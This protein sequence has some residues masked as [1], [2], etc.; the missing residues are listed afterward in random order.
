MALKNTQA[1]LQYYF[2]S[3]E[4]LDLETCRTIT[5]P[6]QVT[7]G[8]II[9]YPDN[10]THRIT[11]EGEAMNIFQKKLMDKKR[12][13]YLK[14]GKLKKPT[15]IIIFTDGFSFSCTSLFIKEM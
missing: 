1:S 6:Y 11:K 5:D 7:D 12:R 4:N 15:E 13:E 3:D 2:F 8:E 14:T 9:G 10:V